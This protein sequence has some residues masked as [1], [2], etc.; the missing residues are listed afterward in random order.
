M[1]H[2]VYLAGSPVSALETM[3]LVACGQV[4]HRAVASHS[5]CSDMTILDIELSEQFALSVQDLSTS[6]QHPAVGRKY[7]IATR[8]DTSRS[9][10]GSVN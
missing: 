5:N 7:G 8:P 3:D 1:S 9:S 2:L 6:E 10:C 4:K